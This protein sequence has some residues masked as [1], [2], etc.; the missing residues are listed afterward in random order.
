MLIEEPD[1]NW[2]LAD[3]KHVLVYGSRALAEGNWRLAKDLITLG[4]QS[5]N[6]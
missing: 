2:S 1:G 3:G 6:S 5:C 4:K